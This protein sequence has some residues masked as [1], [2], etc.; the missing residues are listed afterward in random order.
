MLDEVV[1]RSDAVSR[2]DLEL[3]G[4]VV[5]SHH[6][7]RKRKFKVG[8]VRG[9]LAQV[10]KR[11]H[12]TGSHIYTS[13]CS[14]RGRSGCR[15]PS[16]PFLATYAAGAVGALVMLVDQLVERRRRA[17]V[18]HV[19]APPT[20][21]PHRRDVAPGSC[22]PDTHRQGDGQGETAKDDAPGPGQRWWVVR[23]LN[24]CRGAHGA[25]T[26]RAPPGFRK[27]ASR[28]T[29]HRLVRTFRKPSVLRRAEGAWAPRRSLGTSPMG[30]VRALGVTFG[31][32]VL[33]SA[34]EAGQA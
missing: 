26:V 2:R 33:S 27:V 12:D 34:T 8:E 20:A 5:R 4:M 29:A 3:D 11:R 21:L 22:P 6:V 24:L 17:R 13:G 1:G 19:T 30:H 9:N 14:G 25:L 32:V 23:G 28:F 7:P 16:E 18:A 10:A 15:G 31:G